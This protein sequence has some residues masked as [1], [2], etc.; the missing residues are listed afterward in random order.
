LINQEIKWKSEFNIGDFKIDKEHQH[1]FTIAQKALSLT[2]KNNSKVELIELKKIIF[3]LFTYV[4]D[5]FS[6]EQKY[7]KDINYPEIKSHILLHKN[8]TLMLKDLIDE[9]NSL[10]VIQIKEQLC[11]FINEYFVNHII[12]EDRKIKLFIVPLDELRESFGWKDI[13][14]V[15]DESI[16]LEHKKLFDIASRA[17]SFVDDEDRTKKIKT[18][19][20]ELYDYMKSHFKHEE[21]YMKSISYPALKEQQVLHAEIIELLNTFVKNILKI[22]PILVEK[23][24]AR[25]IDIILVQHIIQE[26]RKI[27]NYVKNTTAHEGLI[28]IKK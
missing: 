14:S 21:E 13:Y 27:I 16:D 8:M 10:E 17:F 23:E 24:I 25:I 26:D 19:V 1:L 11:K 22:S 15:N 6:H 9:F 2:N 3:E 12:L 7:M 5:H 20:I 4:K 28:P 18:I